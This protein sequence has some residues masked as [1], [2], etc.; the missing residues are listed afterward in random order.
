M[1]FHPDA[2]KWRAFT[3]IPHGVLMAISGLVLPWAIALCGVIIFL[4]YEKNED[5]H[6][7]DQ[8]WKDI[9]G[10]MIGFYAVVAV[11]LIAKAIIFLK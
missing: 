11:V 6:T 3:H 8:A 5:R 9:L 1:L 2:D 10:F 7:K 4:F